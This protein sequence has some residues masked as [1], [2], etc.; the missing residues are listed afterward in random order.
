MYILACFKEKL[1][2][3][4]RARQE[5]FSRE[6]QG[7]PGGRVPTTATELARKLSDSMLCYWLKEIW[8]TLWKYMTN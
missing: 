5:D 8:Q 7:E 3:A 2:S 1:Q 6:V 4:R